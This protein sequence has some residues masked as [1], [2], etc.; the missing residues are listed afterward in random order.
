MSEFPYHW[1]TIW[2]FRDHVYGQWGLK[3]GPMSIVRYDWD[4]WHW[5]VCLWN[6]WNLFDTGLRA[7]RQE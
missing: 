5:S 4:G 3:L 2:G 7:H 6:R 1:W